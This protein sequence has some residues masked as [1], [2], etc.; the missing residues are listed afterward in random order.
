MYY[1]AGVK[2]VLHKI[3]NCLIAAVW[4]INGLVCKVMNVVPRYELIVARILGAQ[5]AM[6]FTKLIGV[7]ETCMAIW[8]VWG[9]K[10]R[11]NVWVQI[12]II[13]TMNAIEF[14][15][16]PDLLLF[17][18]MNAVLAGLLIAVIGYN[19]FVL[20]KETKTA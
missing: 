14:V 8:I 18:R 13:A 7:A 9:Y 2:P 19:G 10:A 6:L 15:L 4:L 5:H 20:N 12:L 11:L 16:A 1:F 17:G 3:I